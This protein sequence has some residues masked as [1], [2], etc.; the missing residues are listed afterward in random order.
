[1]VDNLPL[2]AMLARWRSLDRA[3]TGHLTPRSQLGSQ[4]DASSLGTLSLRG[5]QGC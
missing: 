3:V 4:E 1:L 2:K 5:G